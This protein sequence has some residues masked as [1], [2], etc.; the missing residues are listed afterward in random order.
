MTESLEA[1]TI[2][3]ISASSNCALLGFITNFPLIL[4]ALASEIGHSK[5]KSLSCIAA[6]A[7]NP[8]NASGITS[9]S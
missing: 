6:E 7:A 5:G 8:A 2:I 1:P 4:A 9:S 3:S